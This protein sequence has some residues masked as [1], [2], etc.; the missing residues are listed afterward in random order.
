MFWRQV[1]LQLLILK[2][3]LSKQLIEDNWFANTP[4]M[5]LHTAIKKTQQTLKFQSTGSAF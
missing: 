1:V 5:K 4:E 2:L 3:C